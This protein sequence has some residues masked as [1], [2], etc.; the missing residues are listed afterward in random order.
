MSGQQGFFRARDVSLVKSDPSELV[1]RP[2]ELASQV[3]AQFLA[4]HEHL[5]FRI[6][7]R[8]AQPQDLGAV[9]PAAPVEA[10]DG[11]R[12]TPPLHRL[13]PLLGDVILGEAL[14]RADELAVDDTCRERIKVPG[15]C[16]HPGLVEQRQTLLDIP[17]HD[18]QPGFCDPSEGARR[19][20]PHRSQLDGTPG[21]SPCAGQVAG[22]HPLEGADDRNPCV[23]RRLTPTFE[24]PLRSRHPAAHG[25]HEGSVE[26][27][28]HRDANGSACC[29]DLV[30]CLHACGVGAFPRLDGHIEMAGR[31]GD[32]AKHR[33]I[34]GAEEAVSVRLHEQLERPLPVSPRGRVTCSLDEAKT[35]ATA[36]RTPPDRWPT[37]ARVNRRRT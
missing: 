30:P 5:T 13:G 1:Q 16:R 29:R 37:G 15:H 2:S 19:R 18:Q 35:S 23:R 17:V 21:R 10:P 26:E 4:G 24:K 25:C 20:F 36:H 32:L 9:D 6:V 31:I 34:G 33:Q 14:Q 28:V 27:Q 22:Q 12:L 8:S 7:A 3:R 11:T